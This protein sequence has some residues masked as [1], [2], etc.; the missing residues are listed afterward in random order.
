MALLF[1]VLAAAMPEVLVPWLQAAR[2]VSAEQVPRVG[3]QKRCVKADNLSA[4][5][6][7][8]ASMPVSTNATVTRE[9][10]PTSYS[11]PAKALIW[12]KPNCDETKGS[13]GVRL[14]R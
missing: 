11:Q 14:G 9:E 2:G 13:L 10:A 3:W 4:K 7:W 5:S 12:L 6:G 8:V 1:S